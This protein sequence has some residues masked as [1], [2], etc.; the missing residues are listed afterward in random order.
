M[1]TQPSAGEVRR[2]LVA[3]CNDGQFLAAHMR[4]VDSGLNAQL[5]PSLWELVERRAT[6]AGEDALAQ[7][8]RRE[9][10]AA[11][12]A[13]V[14]AV[15]NQARFEIE[16]GQ[17]A[18]ARALIGKAFDGVPDSSEARV[19]LGIA[20]ASEDRTAAIEL[21]EDAEDGSETETLWAVDAFRDL[22]ELHRAKRLC[23]IAITRFPDNPVFFNRLGWIAEGVGDFETA[24][25]AA[26]TNLHGD[27][28][29][30]ARALN[31]LV[32]LYRRLGDKPQAMI[33]AAQLL[34][35]DA[36]WT[37]KLILARTLGQS[38]LLQSIVGTLPALHAKGRIPASETEKIVTFLLDDGQ[39]GLALFLWQ[40]GF[41][42]PAAAKQ[43]LTRKG[44]GDTLGVELPRHIDDAM[45]LRSPDILL[46]LYPERADTALTHGWVPPLRNDEPILLV[47]SVLAAGGAERQFLMVARSLVAAGI[48]PGR[49]HAALF[50]IEHDRGHAHF[51]DALRETGIHVHDL[52]KQDLTSVVLP[53]REQD[54]LTLLPRRL[55]GDVL[56]LYAFAQRLRPSVIHGWQDRACVS[57]ALVSQMLDIRRTVLSVRNMRPSKRGDETDWIAQ[58]VY[59]DVI[60]SPSVAMT[61]NANEGARDYEDWL[62][63][64]HGGVSLLA[65]A[66]DEAAFYP[67]ADPRPAG[68]PIRILGVFRL[69]E[70]KRPLLWIDTMAALRD[71]HGLNIAPRIVGAGP[72]ADEVRRHAEQ[73]G[74]HELRLDPPVEDPSEIYREGDALVLLSQV[75]GTP[76]VVLEAQACGLAVAACDVGGTEEALHLG[77]AS[78]GLLLDAEIDAATAAEAIARWLPS[79]LTAESGPRVRFV[80]DR[81]SKAALAGRLQDLYGAQA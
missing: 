66:V 69:A 48:N 39:V 36:S 71:Q 43:V 72:I 10:L 41:A 23:E 61:A 6:E 29:N 77:G 63:L 30:K 44:F 58:A 3:L 80:H 2:N 26:A 20:L 24:T 17:P 25:S 37:Q 19:L 1:P 68:G 79:A 18:K 9:L 32:R 31:R 65:N 62:N 14:D 78:G 4:L 59:R 67:R 42:M 27:P 35:M 40:E 56:S 70:N 52:S 28:D 21:L 55:R 51:E 8:V 54:L 13:S 57:S 45:E 16:Q 60:A 73:V 11:D 12:V 81:Y 49:L 76:N 47:N 7:R 64:P 15:L 38:Q 53:E 46:P 5:H 50:S 22:G 33:Y 74:L 34:R 75:E